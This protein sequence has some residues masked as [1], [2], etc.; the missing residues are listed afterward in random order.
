MR[1]AVDVGGLAAGDAAV[2]GVEKAYEADVRPA[3]LGGQ[4]GAG[5]SRPGGHVMRSIARPSPHGRVGRSLLAA[6]IAWRDGLQELRQASSRRRINRLRRL[7]GYNRRGSS[8]LRGRRVPW[9]GRIDLA[10]VVLPGR[11]R[12]EESD[13][14]TPRSSKV[15][16][17]WLL[18]SSQRHLAHGDRSHLAQLDAVLLHEIAHH[19][20]HAFAR[21]LA[22]IS[23][24]P[25][26][27]SEALQLED[28]IGVGRESLRRGLELVDVLDS[29]VSPT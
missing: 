12:S 14:H 28:R 7:L 6:E 18:T 8:R 4:V 29:D 21:E 1:E 11:P 20:L 16:R 19:G 15:L 23:V 22:I 24:V 10:Q 26:R 5:P 25:A 2:V 27:I 3:G 9:R 17:A 13:V